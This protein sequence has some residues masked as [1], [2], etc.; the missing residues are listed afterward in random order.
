MPAVDLAD[1]CVICAPD[2][3]DAPFGS[4]LIAFYDTLRMVCWGLAAAFAAYIPRALLL[5]NSGGQR[6][7]F[8]GQLLFALVAV[9]TEVDHFGDNANY[10]LALNVAAMAL[11][12]WGLWEFFREQRQHAA[13]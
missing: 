9:G 11:C 1:F 7:R 5:A 13:E 10:R 2:G 3:P 6:A 12:V 8:A 4:P